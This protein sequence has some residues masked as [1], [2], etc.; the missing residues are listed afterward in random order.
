MLAHLFHEMHEIVFHERKTMA[1]R[2]YV[3]QIWA[4]EHL[5]VCR[6]IFEDAREALEPYIC[7]Y[8]GHITQVHLGKTEHW[9]AR[10]DDLVSVVWRPW[11]ETEDWDDAPREL[12]WMFS[13][14][15]LTGR[16]TPVLE[17]FVISRVWRQYG[18]TQDMSQEYCAY[19]T[20]QR[21]IERGWP[22]QMDPG[23]SMIDILSLAAVQ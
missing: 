7:R 21:D 14:R 15:P 13:S 17:R 12:P 5:P 18:R 3:L 16:T 8:R 9:R 11:R 19:A 6:P 22:P 1:A 2:V 10:L 4:W 23:R 20:L